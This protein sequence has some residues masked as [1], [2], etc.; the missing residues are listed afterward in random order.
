MKR[1]NINKTYKMKQN[2]QDL[3]YMNYILVIQN[4]NILATLMI[5]LSQLKTFMKNFI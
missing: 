1:Q 2:M 3:A 5:F 4:Q